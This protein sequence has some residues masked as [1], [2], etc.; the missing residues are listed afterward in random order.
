MA[1]TVEKPFHWKENTQKLKLDAAYLGVVE[2]NTKGC[3]TS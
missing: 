1:A 2:G 3:K